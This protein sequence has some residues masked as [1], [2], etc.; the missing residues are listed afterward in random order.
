ML[1]PQNTWVV[2]GPSRGDKRELNWSDILFEPSR[3]VEGRIAL[4]ALASLG[5][6]SN[7]SYAMTNTT[8]RS[9]APILDIGMAKCE[10][11]IR[12]GS[13]SVAKRFGAN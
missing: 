12:A 5:S 13:A 10:Q 6:V 7:E 3:V 2:N 11:L 4:R 8:R 9:V 1:T